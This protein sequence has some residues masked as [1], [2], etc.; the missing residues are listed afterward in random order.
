MDVKAV[1]FDWDLTLWNSWDIH[2]WLMRRTAAAL[3][4]PIP[5]A[6]DVA[7]EFHRP[8]YDHLILFFG[9]DFDRTVE[10]YYQLYQEVVAEK[11]HLFRGIPEVL[12]G[13]KDRGYRIGVFSDKR[14]VFGISEL[15]LTGINHLIDYN[16]FLFD[17]RPYK[18]D[19]Q[20]LLHV[21]EMLDVAPS[22]TLYVGDSHQ[23]VECAHR[24][25]AK[26]AAALWASTNE[27]QVLA[28][29]PHFRFERVEQILEALEP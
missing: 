27:D 11:G 20:G 23:D 18:P 29:Q 8:F 10:I 21:L 13:I 9:Q 12:Q 6:T 26:S 22:E 17:D 28:Q 2:L 16:L 25:G 4:S 3:G 19:P 1:V 5:S 14:H 24:A 15:E 7:R